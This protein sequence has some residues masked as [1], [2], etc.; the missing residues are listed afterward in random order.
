MPQKIK[1]ESIYT[2]NRKLK[3]RSFRNTF[4]NQI[5]NDFISFRILH[6]FLKNQNIYLNLKVNKSILITESG[7]LLSLRK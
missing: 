4:L 5:S 2:I 1:K 3:R 6:Y 7:S